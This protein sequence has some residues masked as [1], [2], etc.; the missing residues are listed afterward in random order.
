MELD[1]YR[2]PLFYP[3]I[4]RNKI[5][6]RVKKKKF[7]KLLRITGT[8][9]LYL[10]WKMRIVWKEAVML[11]CLQSNSLFNF[12]K[13]DF[14]KYSGNIHIESWKT[15]N[16]KYKNIKLNRL[17]VKVVANHGVL[18]KVCAFFFFFQRKKMIW[19]PVKNWAA[20]LLL[21]DAV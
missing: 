20:G 18:Y 17:K 4:F 10:K 14:G 3:I 12:K 15:R 8:I 13:Q 19:S 9:I 16:S 11:S 7:L 21:P 2:Y 6:K 5:K 1:N